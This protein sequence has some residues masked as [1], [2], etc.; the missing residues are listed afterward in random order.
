MQQALKQKEISVL[1]I[2]LDS[3]V[4]IFKE[5]SRCNSNYY[6]EIIGKIAMRQKVDN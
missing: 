2:I 3:T 4:A 6:L 5:K 1:L